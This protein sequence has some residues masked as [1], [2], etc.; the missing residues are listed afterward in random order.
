[1]QNN[2]SSIVENLLVNQSWDSLQEAL[3][4]LLSE[5]EKVL[6]TNAFAKACEIYQN[7]YLSSGKPLIWHHLEVA[8]IAVFE[9]G[10][11][12]STVI[13]AFMHS[14]DIK[15]DSFLAQI[16]SDFGKDVA[17][18]LK[19][20]CKI[21]ELPTERLS[22]QSDQFRKLFLTM[23]EDIRV[24]LLKIAHRLFDLRNP[25]DLNKDKARKI[26]PRSKAPLYTDYSQAGIIYYK[27]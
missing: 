10:L 8:K 14:M 7:Q 11:K 4:K 3:E 21:S 23:V 5:D 9:L 26:H 2:D 13:A 6:V 18:I 20:F 1:M 22:Y 19:G 12:S 25:D 24:I 16:E 17:V 27:G 15:N